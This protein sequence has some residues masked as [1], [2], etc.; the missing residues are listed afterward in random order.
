MQE[1]LVIIIVLLAAAAAIYHLICSFKAMNGE[2]NPCRHC[3]SSCNCRLIQEEKER[4][5]AVK[6]RKNIPPCKKSEENRC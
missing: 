4:E 2:D 6:G 3:A 5:K 1:A